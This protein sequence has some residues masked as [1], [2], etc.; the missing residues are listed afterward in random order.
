MKLM[1]GTQGFEDSG[2]QGNHSIPGFLDSLNPGIER[3]G[4]AKK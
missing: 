1:T 4:S 3:N 2:I